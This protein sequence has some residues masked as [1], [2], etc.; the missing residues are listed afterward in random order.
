MLRIETWARDADRQRHREVHCNTCEG[1][2]AAIRTFLR[3]FR[4]VH[5]GYRACSLATSEAVS[6]AKTIPPA[7]I[8][9]WERMGAAQMVREV[10]DQRFGPL[11][12]TIKPQLIDYPYAL[13]KALNLAQVNF[14]SLA[15][16]EAWLAANPVPPGGDPLGPSADADEAAQAPAMPNCG[17]ARQTTA[18]RGAPPRCPTA[19]RNAAGADPAIAPAGVARHWAVTPAPLHNPMTTMGRGGP[20]THPWMSSPADCS[21]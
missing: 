20:T 4:G 1:S 19:Q 8:T 16:R 5:K 17:Q 7:I 10:L 14:S 15:D 12:D 2:G 21:A 18:L 11:S 3:R 6:H 9:R 13:V